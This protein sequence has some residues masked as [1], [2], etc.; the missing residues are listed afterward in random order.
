MHRSRESDSESK[1]KG[2]DCFRCKYLDN[3]ESLELAN[4]EL[5]DLSTRATTLEN[6]FQLLSHLESSIKEQNI[7]VRGWCEILREYRTGQ[8]EQNG[9]IQTLKEEVDALKDQLFEIKNVKE[10]IW[11]ISRQ[12][13]STDTLVRINE[14]S[15]QHIGKEAGDV[16]K[17]LNEVL[18]DSMEKK[19]GKDFEA[20]LVMTLRNLEEKLASAIQQIPTSPTFENT[21]KGIEHL[22]NSIS[23]LSKTHD[24]SIPLVFVQICENLMKLAEESLRDNEFDLANEYH[25]VAKILLDD[26]NRLYK[27]PDLS[28]VL[29]LGR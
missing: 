13:N 12:Y 2:G 23:K 19:H 21:K 9:H 10:R 8:Q 26:I 18:S 29:K 4:K 1:L 16:L 25:D 22:K 3:L 24:M 14:A 11:G 27:E 6:S 20:A 5:N 28:R 15:E 7:E 17:I